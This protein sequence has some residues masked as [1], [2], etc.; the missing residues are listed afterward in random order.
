[1]T[2]L[3]AGHTSIQAVVSAQGELVSA[4]PLLMNLQLRAGGEEGGPLAIPQLAALA[5]LALRLNTLISR[6]VLAA[7]RDVDIDMWVRARP[8]HGMVTLT[9]LDWKERDVEP[10]SP[11]IEQERQSDLVRA[12]EGWNWRIDSELRF[13]AMPRIAPVTNGE[14]WPEAG[15]LLTYF[16][17]LEEG[18]DHHFPILKAMADR[19]PF[20][21]QK[22]TVRD[23][24]LERYVLSGFPIFDTHGGLVGYRGKAAAYSGPPSA[25]GTP[26]PEH[27]AYA[28]M[29]GQRLDRALRKP[30]G[31]IIANAETIS[32]QL[33]GPLRRDYA[34]YASDIAA[35]GRHLMELVDDLADLQAI[36]RP[37]F[38]PVME[39]VDLA[40]I[41]RR[42]VG[43]LA[44]KAS[45]RKIRIEAPGPDESLPATGEFR[46]SLQI[47]VNLVGNAIR[48]APENSVVSIRCERDGEWAKVNVTDE[49]RGI[50]PEDQEKIF[51]KF[52]RLGRDEAGGSGLGLYISRRLARA[53]Q[54]D[55]T[56]QSAPGEG[57]RFT[58]SMKARGEG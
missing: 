8:D 49:G 58:L 19:V 44:V 12:A 37:D 10:Q 27:G 24:P 7:D 16:F 35:A 40:D 42:T 47:L 33:Q 50:A 51:D 57:A 4:D 28:H 11:V 3:P 14:N 9:I 48:Y 39:D 20:L 26:T 36:E 34:N 18:E 15:T 1:M 22:A 56:V 32:G 30:L 46:R 29:F 21:D 45:D 38:N 6:P 2:A 43:L 52:E 53:M 5:R 31:R 41:A 54:G 23:R 25:N 55:V 13:L 17:K